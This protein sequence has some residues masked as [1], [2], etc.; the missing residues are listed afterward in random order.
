MEDTHNFRG[1][2]QP[3]NDFPLSLL[4]VHGAFLLWGTIDS[5]LPSLYNACV[6]HTG[7]IIQVNISRGGVP[8]L[9]VGQARVF[10]DRLEGDDWNDRKH[11]GLSGQAVCLFSVELI[12]E[13]KTEGY[14]LFPGALGENLTTEGID[15]RRVRLGDRFRVGTEVEIRITKI[16]QPCR[17][18][19]VYGN[20]IIRA[21]FDAEV[22][23][24]NT[25]SFKWGRS[26]YYAEVLKEGIAR[27]GDTIELLS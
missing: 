7:R 4:A 21:T 6:N 22:K 10:F 1:Q 27:P 23:A 5:P 2:V 25:S 26:G 14:P 9:P 13:L 20:G 16:R 8:K 12:A 17:T 11:H 15:Y 24:G 19:T 18:I 3:L